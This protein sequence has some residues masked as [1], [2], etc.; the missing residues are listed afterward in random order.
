MLPRGQRLSYPIGFGLPDNTPELL[1]KIPA[2]L[3][4][5]AYDAH[6]QIRE[7]AWVAELTGL[8]DLTGWRKALH[9]G[10]W[11]SLSGDTVGARADLD[12]AAAVAVAIGHDVL[13][14]QAVGA[15]E[16]PRKPCL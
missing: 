15:I 14:A 9:R 12:E 8:L 5:L 13:L 10:V 4:T 3:W 1:E 7:G 2:E 16:G 6:D 11:R